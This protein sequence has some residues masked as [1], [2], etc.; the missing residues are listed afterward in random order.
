MKGSERRRSWVIL[1]TV[2]TAG[3]A[4]AWMQNKVIPLVSVFVE[5]YDTDLS[6]VG[7]LSSIFCVMGVVT[8]IPAAMILMKIGPKYCG[9]IAL[10]SAAI[11]AVL[12]IFAE[13]IVVM[14]ISR[15]IEGIGVGIISVAAPSVI[16]MWFPEEKRGLPMGIWGSWQMVGQ[17]LVFFLAVDIMTG[18]GWKGMWGTGILLCAAAFILYAVKVKKPP[19]EH[20]YAN[21]E[22]S[23]KLAGGLKAPSVWLMGAAGFLFCCCCFGWITWIA[24]YWTDTFL[25]SEAQINLYLAYMF[26]LEIPLVIG[27]GWMFDK[28]QSKRKLMGFVGSLIYAALLLTG[29]MLKNA[30]FLIPYIIAYPLFEGVVATY[31]WTSTPQTVSNPRD[32]GTALAVLAACMNLGSVIGPPLIGIVIGRFGYEIAGWP[33]AVMMIAAALLVLITKIYT[34][35]GEKKIN[36]TRQNHEAKIWK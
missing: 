8:A 31:L 2:F 10:G 30:S 9:L 21:I 6:T 24:I 20:N 18:F 36:N 12:G 25:V 14:M 32:T 13:S 27:I 16:S 28:F 5:A 3:V 34:V 29:Y 4:L 35:S 33:L 23:T 15:V 22:A 7:W 26:V 19:E 11:G 1:L 17:S